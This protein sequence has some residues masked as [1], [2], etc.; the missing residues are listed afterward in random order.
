MS[1]PHYSAIFMVDS[2]KSRSLFWSYCCKKRQ[3]VQLAIHWSSSLKLPESL[4]VFWAATATAEGFDTGP[5][6]VLKRSPVEHAAPPPGCRPVFSRNDG[7]K[8]GGF[9][10]LNM[11]FYQNCWKKTSRARMGNI[12]W[13]QPDIR[14]IGESADENRLTA[15][16]RMEKRDITM[17]FFCKKLR[18]DVRNNQSCRLETFISTATSTVRHNFFVVFLKMECSDHCSN[19]EKKPS[20]PS[21]HCRWAPNSIWNMGSKTE[22]KQPSQSG[23]WLILLKSDRS[24]LHF[25]T[26]RL[27]L[28]PGDVRLPIQVMGRRSSCLQPVGVFRSQTFELSWAFQQ[29]WHAT[30]LG[31]KSMSFHHFFSDTWTSAMKLPTVSK[32]HRH[33]GSTGGREFGK[34]LWQRGWNMVGL[35]FPVWSG[36]F[37]S[38]SVNNCDHNLHKIGVLNHRKTAFYLLYTWSCRSCYRLLQ[39]PSV[40]S[41]CDSRIWRML[42]S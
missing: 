25:F 28:M 6:W 24:K 39:L 36:G 17:A 26:V 18:N 11:S 29:K 10:V 27:Q 13:R 7:T 15:A 40:S 16:L 41:H 33:L 32:T 8:T 35:C 42:V 23:H 22:T 38:W 1:N 4:F 5:P 12:L 34:L 9:L 20:D 30:H 2:T 19:W 21:L 37:M 3:K 14:I 31:L